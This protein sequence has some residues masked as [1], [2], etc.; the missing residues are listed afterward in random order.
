MVRRPNSVPRGRD[1]SPSDPMHHHRRPESVRLPKAQAAPHAG[2][3]A[4]V[5]HPVNLGG[6]PLLCMAGT[7]PQFV[8]DLP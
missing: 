8:C 1:L 3:F 7:S 6:G 4:T 5:A 2:Q